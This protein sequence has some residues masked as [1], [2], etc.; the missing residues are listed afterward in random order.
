MAEI[1]ERP[2]LKTD[3]IYRHT[4]EQEDVADGDLSL[5]V[6]VPGGQET[7]VTV[8]SSKPVMDLLI[9]LC[10][11][12]HLNPSDHFIELISTNQNHIKFK[13]SSL[14]GSLEAERVVLKPKGSE[15]NTKRVPNMPIATVRLII[16]Y[17]QSHKAVVRVNPRVPLAELL[18]AVC[19]KCEFDP[20]STI[21]LR[22]SQSEHPLDLT[23][24]LNDYGIRDLYAKDT[25]AVSSA[26]KDTTAPTHKGCKKEKLTTVKKG[27]EEKENRGLFSLFRRSKKMTE[28]RT[29]SIS[30]A[31]VCPPGNNHQVVGASCPQVHLATPA[32]P[33]N[34][35]KKRRAPQPPRML[36]FQGS[37]QSVSLP[38]ATGDE[39][40]LSRVSC[41]ESSLKRKK[42]RAPPPPCIN[43]ALP[44]CS[45]EEGCWV[46][47]TPN[48]T[49]LDESQ[50]EAVR[51]A[52]QY[53]AFTTAC[54]STPSPSL[55]TEIL[56]EYMDILKA[57]EQELSSDGS[58]TH[59]PPAAFHSPA[60]QSEPSSP[61]SVSDP[62]SIAPPGCGLLRHCS[63]REGLTTFTV[64]PRR[65][66]PSLRHYEVLVRLETPG[67]GQT[68]HLE[69]GSTEMESLEPKE[70]ENR[71]L[72]SSKMGTAEKT[73]GEGENL[74]ERNSGLGILEAAE[75]AFGKLTVSASTEKHL[76]VKERMED[77]VSEE[78]Q[79]DNVEK[80]RESRS[81]FH[82]HGSNLEEKNNEAENLEPKK[83]DSLELNGT[84]RT[85][86]QSE[87]L[88]DGNG[89][90]GVLEAARKEKNWVE[91]HKERRR[92]QGGGGLDRRM[93]EF[94]EGMRCRETAEL[95]DG[96]PPP[97]SVSWEERERERKV[98]R[99][100]DV[101]T[102]CSK[103]SSSDPM[104]DILDSC[105]AVTL[106]SNLHSSDSRPS[107]LTVQPRDSSRSQ[108]DS[109][110]SSRQPGSALAPRPEPDSLFSPTFRSSDVSPSLSTVSLF[111]LAVSQRAQ[112]LRSRVFPLA[113]SA[114]WFRSQSLPFPGF[115][116]Q[117]LPSQTPP[118]LGFNSQTPP[119]PGLSSQSFFPSVASRPQPLKGNTGKTSRS[120]R[121]GSCEAATRRHAWNSPLRTHSE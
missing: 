27:Q 80:Y 108:L 105:C 5:T 116:S 16:N 3:S 6:Q 28:E 103:P 120:Q 11:Q 50:E 86:A 83:P 88:E 15:D 53:D 79:G 20:N 97:R 31:L 89:E 23:K 63:L 8:N 76:E 58:V 85:C 74:E 39:G 81:S 46:G 13:P 90:Q 82:K 54:S 30:G 34:I 12:Y 65:R 71:K 36:C 40:V 7:S 21:L 18:P 48:L 117:T 10:A 113:P 33:V 67:S 32:P 45:D 87:N 64:V 42:Q 77:Q 106:C 25:K 75:K 2:S 56:Y 44:D 98:K 52:S 26:S 101:C 35:P 47:D 9:S 93:E 109:S 69:W 51:S 57:Q 4:M 73:D 118:P 70:V 84:E 17:R 61:A 59:S 24:T 19:D 22:D 95:E 102:V 43:S 62:D 92:F 94:E 49:L 37:S 72:N 100:E 115:C 111:A 99:G 60:L 38:A 29:P 112:S 104:P 107:P 110:S 96:C 78:E 119:S 114:Q 121:L 91:E 68:D 41:T 14:I 1:P 66:Q 55:M